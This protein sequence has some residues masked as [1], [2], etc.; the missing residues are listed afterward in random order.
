MARLE[1]V[2]VLHAAIA[3]GG[4]GE[5]IA[6]L[7][8]VPIL[9]QTRADEILLEG[10]EADLFAGGPRLARPHA[11]ACHG[12][13]RLTLPGRGHEPS[14]FAAIAARSSDFLSERGER[15]A[16]GADL[17]QRRVRHRRR[18]FVSRGWRCDPKHAMTYW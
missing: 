2:T 14:L 11:G 9:E 17:E 5:W 3:G 10:G 18:R 6:A 13:P 1:D 8:V 16:P 7:P 4:L 15:A 12:D